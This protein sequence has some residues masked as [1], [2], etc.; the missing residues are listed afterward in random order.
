MTNEEK[1]AALLKMHK[2]EE[3]AANM[4]Y[5]VWN[6]GEIT[7][8][9]GGDLYG[10]RG[11]HMINFGNEARG[12]PAKALIARYEHSRII[13]SSNEEAEAARAIILGEQT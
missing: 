3:Q 5:E 1:I 9:K 13:V 10:L 11:L 7:L 8:T 2:P 4:V 12:L 6:D